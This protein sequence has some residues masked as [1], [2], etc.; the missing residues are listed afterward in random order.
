[1][2]TNEQVD[3]LE[4]GYRARWRTFPVLGQSSVVRGT[5]A[6]HVGSKGKHFSR[7]HADEKKEQLM[8]EVSL[9]KSIDSE[10]SPEPLLG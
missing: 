5:G 4:A 8:A 1:M 9:W 3:E 7:R 6:S 2:L 10:Q